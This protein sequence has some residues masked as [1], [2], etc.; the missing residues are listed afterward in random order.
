MSGLYLHIP[1]CKQAC[2][3]CNFH[4]STSL[5]YK[6]RMVQAIAKELELQAALFPFAGDDLQSVYFGGGTPSLLSQDELKVLWQAIHQ[7]F[8]VHADAEITLE[9]NPDDLTAEQLDL[10]RANGINRLSIG[11]QS[12]RDEDLSFMNRAH[13]AEEARRCV[14]LA[15]AAGFDQ[16]SIDLIYGIPGCSDEDW[17]ANVQQVIDWQVPHISA[18]SL[19]VEPGTALDAFIR[20]GKATPVDDQKTARQFELLVDQLNSAGYQ[21][22]EISNFALPGQEAQHNS[23]YWTGKPYLGV[24]PS[25]HSFDGKNRQWNIAH[26]AQYMKAI[27]SGSI[28]YEQEV[29]SRQDQ[30][31]ERIMTGLRT[32][33]GLSMLGLADQFPEFMTAFQKDLVAVKTDGFLEQDGDLLRLTMAGKLMGDPVIAA[34]FQVE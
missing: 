1:F 6:P 25:A 4:F 12:F 30:F 24:G 27:E 10:F 23:S 18:Y 11:I 8:K 28:P 31:N 17:Q 20:K 22:Y 32:F 2:H 3:Y 5:R 21:H 14:E 9:A 19:T 13:N 15:R 29:L 34:L 16:L 26:N 33:K 7:H